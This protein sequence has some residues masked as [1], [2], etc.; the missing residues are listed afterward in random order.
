MLPPGRGL[1]S[2]RALAW[3]DP[4]LPLARAPTGGPEMTQPRWMAPLA[5]AAAACR[6]RLPWERGLRRAA[7]AA[8]RPKAPALAPPAR[9]ASRA[10]R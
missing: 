10:G 3:P 9:K 7:A 2:G 1:W 5:A 4:R 8:R 6:T